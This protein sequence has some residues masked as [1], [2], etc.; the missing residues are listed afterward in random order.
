M[1]TTRSREGRP[2]GATGE[3]LQ[4]R[5]ETILHKELERRLDFLETGDD[6]VFALPLLILGLM[7]L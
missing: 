3:I 5:R 1:S 7:V 2:G 4:E 6:S